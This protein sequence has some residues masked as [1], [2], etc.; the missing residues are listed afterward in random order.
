MALSS[1]RRAFT[2]AIEPSSRSVPAEGGK[3]NAARVQVL[4]ALTAL[5]VLSGIDQAEN[6]GNP[7]AN[8][9]QKPGEDIVVHV[10]LDG[11]VN[12]GGNFILIEERHIPFPDQL[13]NMVHVAAQDHPE[14]RS[15]VRPDLPKPV[16]VAAVDDHGPLLIPALDDVEKISYLF[17][18]VVFRKSDCSEISMHSRSI[19]S[20]VSRNVKNPKGDPAHMPDPLQRSRDYSQRSEN[21]FQ[22]NGDQ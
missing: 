7:H 19:I 2:A 15:E 18:T 6:E 12:V 5:H 13:A 10:P 4:A 17:F 11:A 3:G 8:I 20:A 16:T 14:S 22:R 21:S 1:P 9:I